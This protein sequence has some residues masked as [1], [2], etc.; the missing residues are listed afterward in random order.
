MPDGG[1]LVVSA[2]ADAGGLH[3]AV[4]DTGEGIA[5]EDLPHVFEPFYS[6]RPG[7]SGLGLA[8]VHRVV[9]DHGGEVEVRSAPGR[10]TTVR[11]SLP[12]PA[13]APVEA[14]RG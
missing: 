6:T 3:I 14:A 4:S 12:A 8:L 9:Q 2:A 10:S 7:G 1:E 5:P 11:L 13:G